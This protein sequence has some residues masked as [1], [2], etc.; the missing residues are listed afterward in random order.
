MSSNFL[1]VIFDQL[2]NQPITTANHF[3]L[4]VVPSKR[5]LNRSSNHIENIKTYHLQNLSPW[6][7]KYSSLYFFTKCVRVRVR[8]RVRVL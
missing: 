3:H 6:F 8:V 2:Y 5:G 4:R 1:D 7:D